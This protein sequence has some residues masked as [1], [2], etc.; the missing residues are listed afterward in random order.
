MFEPAILSVSLLTIMASAAV[1]PALAE[2]RAAFPGSSPTT[3]KLLLTLP[4]LVLIP[5]S[6]LSGW[7]ASRV[8]KKTILLVGSAIYTIG[9]IGAGLARS[10]PELLVMRGVLGV[11]IGLIMPLSNSLI[12][13]FFEGPAR[14]RMMGLSG[15]VTNVGGVL[16]LSAA[17]WLAT[18]N[19]RLA[20]AV[21]A[22]ALVT[23]FLVARWLPEPPAVR[24]PARSA[25]ARI[26]PGLLVYALLGTLMMAA[27]YVVPTSLALFLED[28]RSLFASERPLFSSREELL[29]YAAG[30]GVSEA[31]RKE[32][33][34]RGI[35][36]SQAASI[37]VEEAG[38]RWVV[39]DGRRSYPVVKGEGF[40]GVRAERLG[41]PTLAGAILAT[42]T[43]S[44]AL[45]GAGLGRIF[46][47]LR[48]YAV[49]AAIAL[50]A[51]GFALLGRAS[52]VA[53]VFAAVPFIGLAAGIMLPALLLRVP[54]CVAPEARAFAMALVGSAIYFGQFIS[55]LVLNGAAVVSG[56]DT[57]RFRFGF[58]AASLLLAAL[59]ALGRALHGSA[60]VTRA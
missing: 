19:W 30:G 22:L 55:P 31:L 33:A 10:M 24:G 43:L 3:V 28:E 52:S 59:V 49:P 32:F 16:L 2:I 18:R 35:E 36:L 26:A 45:A 27:F 42:M 29:R 21:Y 39:R 34:V 50:M 15:S 37:R 7:L 38:R 41:R 13:D 58:V 17:G 14:T 23:M 46:R 60:R 11:G 6:L 9:G 25:G 47:W 48:G 8:R 20:F 4:S 5:F 40:L 12:A 53:Q 57:F 56:H 51:T 44:G 1:A 54:Q